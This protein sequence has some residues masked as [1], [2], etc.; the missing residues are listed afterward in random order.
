MSKIK[1]ISQENGRTE[2]IH[3]DHR[4]RLRKELLDCGFNV[5]NEHRLLEFIL[6][7]CYSQI[8]TNPI[9]HNLINTFG[10]L[11]N[12]LEASYSELIKVK[13]VGHNTATFLTSLLP[14][15]NYYKN[16]K[17]NAKCKITTTKDYV[18][19]FGERIKHENEEKI[20]LIFLNNKYEVFK[21]VIVSF[22]DENSVEVKTNLIVNA[23]LSNNTDK[24]IAMHN[25]PS[26]NPTPSSEDL[27]TTENLFYKLK[28]LNINLLDHIIVSTNGYYSFKEAGLIEKYIE[29]SKFGV[30]FIKNTTN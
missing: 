4:K 3:K 18:N 8:D 20:L 11:A 24:I 10:S 14:I 19:Y 16:Q 22:G 26:G 9:A 15:F 6:F 23:T 13:G 5:S 25:H 30:K 28:V 17:T 1:E 2:N 27:F 12:V 7:H 29:N 21:N